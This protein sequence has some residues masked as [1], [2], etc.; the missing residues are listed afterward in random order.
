MGEVETAHIYVS[1]NNRIQINIYP[2]KAQGPVIAKSII[3]KSTRETIGTT[4]LKFHSFLR[5]RE[6]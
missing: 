4:K 5:R 6:V 1:W 2:E 3:G